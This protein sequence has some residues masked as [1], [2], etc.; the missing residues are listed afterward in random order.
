ML[1]SRRRW[2]IIAALA[3][4]S[5]ATIA[6]LTAYRLW[7]DRAWPPGVPGVSRDQAGFVD[8][9]SCGQCHAAQSRAWSGSHHDRAMQRAD[10]TTVL[11]DF[12]DARLTLFGVTSRFFTRAGRFFVNTEGPDGAPAD[13]EITYTF[14]IAPLQQYLIAF[15]GGRL[16]TLTIAWDTGRKRWFALYPGVKISPADPLHW[17]GRYQNW[18]L[19]CA[20]CHT[21]NLRKGYDPTTDSYKTTWSALHVGCQACHGPGQA[22]LAWARAGGRARN[23]AGIGLLVSFRTTDSR[24]QVDVCARCHSRRTRLVAAEGP[25]RPLLDEFRPEL[26][27][28][29]LYHA[30][31]QQLGEVYEYGSFR[32]S[33]MYQRGVRCTD[34][35]DPHSGK[36]RAA[37]DALCT[38][39]HSEQ[40]DPRF[41]TLTATSYDSPAHHF[42]APGSAGARCVGCHMPAKNYM[43]VDARR[44]HSARVPRPDLSVKLGTPNACTACHADRS[45]R[46]AAAAAEKW[47]GPRVRQRPHDAE[48]LA[49]GRTGARNAEPNLVALARDSDRPA[50]VRAT[51]LDLLR[52]YGAGGAAA[53]IRATRDEDPVVRVAAIGA[54]D[55]LPP[56]ERLAAAAPSL[57]DPIRAV[58]IEA[59]RVLASV[60]ADLFDASQR[61]AFNAALAQF[62]DA[63]LAMADMPSA[64]WSLGVVYEG[65]GQ[66]D[67]AERAY[68]A[69]L[70]MD[71]N[72]FQARI[73]LANLYDEMRRNADA[74][75]VLREGIA[76]PPEHGELPYSLGLLLVENG[77]LPEA[78]GA[79]QEAVRLLPDRA[80]VRYNYGVVLQRLGRGADAEAALREALELDR[81]DPDIAYALAVL[82][83]QRRQYTRALTYARLFSRLVPQDPRA[84][85]LASQIERARG[86]AE[87]R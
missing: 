58:R 34:C 37:G 70:R 77:R 72:F 64:Q 29:D 44:D 35:H 10:A 53:A 42:H 63:Q 54:L 60:P 74:E 39:C 41:P 9:R 81:G 24:Y 14:G 73:N 38:R 71:P 12:N 30:D 33:T 68:Q 13:F 55:R 78:A 20:E 84:R 87:R 56:R 18:N 15:P 31:G 25:G 52:Q 43:L 69:A 83:L 51:A 27:R 48:V 22:H 16:Q 57:E 75:R 50:I 59:A 32:Q 1:D 26:L 21:T 23:S 8:E 66:H 4:G 45:A 46:W 40:S 62:K 79:L 86:G 85:R 17:T 19:M 82:Y 6:V 7:V 3:V 2:R 80:R 65:L 67:S 28:A 11:A 36:P 5:V 47:W 49:A 76:R 61:R